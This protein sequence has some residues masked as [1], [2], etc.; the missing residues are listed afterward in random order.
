MDSAIKLGITTHLVLKFYTCFPS[1]LQP[2]NM[3][4]GALLQGEEPDEGAN[5]DD[6]DSINKECVI[7]D[8]KADC[9]MA[10]LDNGPYRK[11]KCD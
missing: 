7:Q 5:D 3:E 4:I 10:P 6:A 9:N 8:D 1:S 2:Q 11:G